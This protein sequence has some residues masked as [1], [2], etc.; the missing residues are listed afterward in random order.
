MLYKNLFRKHYFHQ[1]TL[2]TNVERIFGLF[3]F[4]GAYTKICIHFEGVIHE[5]VIHESLQSTKEQSLK[6]IFILVLERFVFLEHSTLLIPIPDSV[7][8][9]PAQL[10]V[11]VREAGVC[12]DQ[13]DHGEPHPSGGEG[14]RLDRIT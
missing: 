14:A 1:K 11:P 10:E 4:E 12:W 8:L 5:G 7:L 6:I 9:V 3:D 2:S 13:G